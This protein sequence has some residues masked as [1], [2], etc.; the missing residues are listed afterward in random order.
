MRRQ[1]KYCLKQWTLEKHLRFWSTFNVGR[2]TTVLQD[3]EN[4]RQTKLLVAQRKEILAFLQV[5]R[6]KES[7][8][9]LPRWIKYQS[10]TIASGQPW[11]DLQWCPNPQFDK[12]FLKSK[13]SSLLE[14]VNGLTAFE[15]GQ[16]LN[17]SLLPKNQKKR[18]FNQKYLITYLP[19]IRWSTSL[20]WIVAF[21]S[22]SKAGEF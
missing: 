7:K 14:S 13:K 8:K 4:Y 19:V 20:Y 1:K 3:S 16:I 2:A 12:K 17:L 9:P 21:F 6:K 10:S 22:T 5:Y 11:D 18:K 15:R